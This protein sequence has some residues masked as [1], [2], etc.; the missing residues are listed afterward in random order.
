MCGA[1]FLLSFL[2]TLEEYQLKKKSALVVSDI[3]RLFLNVLKPDE[4]YTPSV[5]AKF[6][7]TNSNAM[8]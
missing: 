2:I 4:K 6:N 7:V 1:V 5:K 3:L 8:I